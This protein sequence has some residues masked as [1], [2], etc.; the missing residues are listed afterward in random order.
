VLVHLSVRRLIAFLKHNDVTKP[1]LGEN[2]LT[3]N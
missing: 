2:E 3:T 1:E